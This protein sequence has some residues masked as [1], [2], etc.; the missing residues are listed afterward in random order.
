MLI[1]Y[2]KLEIE[3]NFLHIIKS[4]Y[5]NKIKETISFVITYKK[6]I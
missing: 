2:R 4:I 1:I 6:E 5:E 3:E